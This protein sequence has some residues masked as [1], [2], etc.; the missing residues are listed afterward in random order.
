MQDQLGWE[1]EP[2]E[3][4]QF[5]YTEEMEGSGD[6]EA[7][8]PFDEIEEMELATSLLEVTDEAELEQ[9]IS[10]ILRRVRRIGGKFANSAA[11]QAVGGILKGAARK[12]LP[13]IGSAIGSALGGQ[14]GGDIGSR[15]ASGAGRMFGLELEGLSPE[16]QEFEAARAYVR[17]AGAAANKATQTP[18]NVAPQ[19]AAQSAAIAAARQHAPGLLRGASGAY[20]TRAGGMRRSGRW[21]RQGR[22]I[23][24]VN[25]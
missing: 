8:S 17:F 12:V 14:A 1:S 18:P 22:N 25:C 24:I 3:T 7:E 4:D 5:E 20:P 23:I 21:V 6:T 15:L 11:G 19:A 9:F 2:F 10:N 16:D 13:D